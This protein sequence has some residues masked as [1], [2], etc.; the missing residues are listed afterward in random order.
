[1]NVRRLAVVLAAAAL[2]MPSIPA[3]AQTPS[4]SE[5]INVEVTNIDVVVTDRSGKRIKGLTRDAFEVVEN[6][7]KRE[8]TNFSEI[9]TSETVAVEQKPAPRRILILFD[10]NQITFGS[11]KK[12]AD[13]ARAMLKNVIRPTDRV[14]VASITRSVT[15]RIGWTTDHAALET[16]FRQIEQESITGATPLQLLERRMQDVVGFT[17]TGSDGS[18]GAVGSPN[19][20]DITANF[21]TLIGMA[22]E[23]AATETFETRQTLAAI[24]SSLG[25]FDPAAARKIV[26]IVGG[27]VTT[28]PGYE[29]FQLAQK[30]KERIE[31]DE[32]MRRRV[33]GARLASPLLEAGSYNTAREIETLAKRAHAKGVAFYST[34]PEYGT[35]VEGSSQDVREDSIADFNRTATG[36]DGFQMLANITGGAVLLGAPA[37]VAMKFVQQ[38]LEAYYSIGFKS[39]GS[40]TPESAKITVKAKGYNTRY[41][42]SGG[43]LTR[44]EEIEEWVMSNHSVDPPAGKLEIALEPGAITDD[45]GRRVIPMNILIPGE[46]IQLTRNNGV[47]QGGVTIFI[48]V[49]GPD[50]TPSRP[51]RR[52][53][54]I[55]WTNEQRDQM[56]EEALVVSVP[57]VLEPGR[58][59]V[60][61]GVMDVLSGNAGFTRWS[62][63]EAAQP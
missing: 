58:D 15:P 27:R 28:R 35:Q 42:L 10:Q 1:M 26:I 34:N 25:L 38:D 9:S 63:D 8:I 39:S 11:R 14:A 5:I 24:E 30:V 18:D 33:R 13:A 32:E 19:V 59:R 22:R 52:T 56:R 17:R 45:R 53:Q 55:R 43:K 47:W 54:E 4:S 62:V 3:A 20:S 7:Q 2:L 50:G 49:S 31:N 57:I 46:G 41:T 36:Y 21:E 60:S 51:V 61:I 37:D 12:M 48:S 40:D 23:Y 6:G 44:D 29:M 16:V